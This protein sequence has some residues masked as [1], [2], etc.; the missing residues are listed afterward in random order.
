MKAANSGAL[1]HRLG[2]EKT[3]SPH[4]RRSSGRKRCRPRF[5]AQWLRLQ[6]LEKMIPTTR[7][8]RTDD[9]LA[10]AMISADRTVLRQHRPRGSQRR[11]IC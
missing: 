7:C 8:S 9:T 10:Q 2:L 4:A 5:A 3:G 1:R 11:W 6:D